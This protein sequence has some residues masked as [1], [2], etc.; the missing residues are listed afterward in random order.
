MISERMGHLNKIVDQ[1]L[2]Y[3]RSTEPQLAPVRVNEVIDD[4]LLLARP[5]LRQQ[6]VELVTDLATRL[7]MLNADRHQLEQACL[8]LIL[9]AVDAM[10]DG[11]QLTVRSRVPEADMVELV[12]V[13]SGTGIDE[14]VR[15]QLFQPFLT[16]KRT[17]TGL[18]LA[19]VQK[20]VEAHHGRVKVESTPG[21]GTTIRLVF[22][23][24]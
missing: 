22:K 11:G 24:N 5:R 8:N 13:D 18:G 15:S 3:A 12:F 23:V 19:I 17:G 2:G 14:S 20:I 6:G 1:L 7:P 4:I 16:T 10:P 21:H 9:N